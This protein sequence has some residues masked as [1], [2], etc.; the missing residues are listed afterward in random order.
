MKLFLD[1]NLLIDYYAAREPYRELFVKLQAM[2][3]FGDAELWASA[4]SFTD[5]FF[6]CKKHIPAEFLQ[7][8]FMSSQE[9]LNVC[10]INQADILEAARRKWPDFED[11]LV[12]LAA[13]K[14]QADY[15]ITRDE[16]GFSQSKVKAIHPREL[17]ETLSEQGLYYED[18]PLP[19]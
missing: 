14:V 16:N 12:A 5:V 6:V 15:L 18:I 2:Q 9:F 8:A 1:T 10:S 17:F 3:L 19:A 4:K 7:D 11:C 13:E